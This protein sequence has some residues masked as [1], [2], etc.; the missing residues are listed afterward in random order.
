MKAFN[1]LTL[2]TLCVLS[3]NGYAADQPRIY[4]RSLDVDTRVYAIACPSGEMA[5]VTVRYDIKEQD[6]QQVSEEARRLRAGDP[7]PK[8]PNIIEV[9]AYPVSGNDKVCSASMDLQQA[10]QKACN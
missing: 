5:S 10:A 2:T 1:T 9:C 8:I 7:R 4:D 3:A 6:T